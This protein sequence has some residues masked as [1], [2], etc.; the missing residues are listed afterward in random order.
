M[1]S[2]DFDEI[3][4]LQRNG[5]WAESG[6]LLAEAAKSI[7][8]AGADFLLLCTNTMH[9]V[10][11]D[12]VSKIS[13]PFLHIAD[14]TAERL[15]DDGIRCVGLLGTR[16]TMEQEFYKG[17]ISDKYGIEVIVPNQ[18]QR[19]LIHKVIYEELCLGKIYEGSKN[20]F[21]E[22]ITGL[23]KAGAE[24]VILGCTEIG[25]L[26]NQADV[27]VPL[28]DTTYIHAAKAVERALSKATSNKSSHSAS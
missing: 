1:Y 12:I 13:I 25:L 9:K 15:T 24:A 6:N 4:K 22:I 3:E 23:G 20:Q 19:E 14:A 21:V 10:S 28:Y 2:V 5:M 26:V 16:F 8:A 27:Q 17:R 11:S 18:D 7:E